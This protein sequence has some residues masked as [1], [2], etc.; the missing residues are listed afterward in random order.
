MQ[1]A[2][3]WACGKPAFGIRPLRPLKIAMF[4]TEDDLEELKSFRASMRA[5][6]R[7]LH[8]WTDLELAGAEAN[9]R[10][11]DTK[12]R[13][14]EGFVARLREVQSRG[15]FDLVIV[16]PLQGVTGFDIAQ[17]ALLT[18]FLREGLDSVLKDERLKCGLFV[19]HHTNKP[20][21]VRD[22]SRS[23]ARRKAWKT[24][25]PRYEKNRHKS[26]SQK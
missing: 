8:G 3:A 24:R 13:T 9:I 2:Y 7:A 17:N 5:G 10:F 6:Y 19:I 11:Y 12:G 26:S 23:L 21:S 14:S 1:L 20:P 16:N 4:Q 18:K 22:R 25:F 15:L